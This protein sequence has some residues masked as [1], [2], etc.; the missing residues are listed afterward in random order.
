MSRTKSQQDL[1]TALAAVIAS[2]RRHPDD[3]DLRQARFLLTRQLDPTLSQRAAARLLGVSHTGLSRWIKAGDLATV[4][5]PA[6]RARLPTQAVLD[7]HDRLVDG[8]SHRLEAAIKPSHDRAMK[9]DADTLL[10]GRGRAGDAHRRAQDRAL[11]YHRAV[12]GQLTDALILRARQLLD[13][14]R[15]SGHI[16]DRWADAW[17]RLLGQPLEVIAEQISRDDEH[18][19]DLRQNSPF[20]GALSEAERRT[21]LRATR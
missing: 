13:G 1:L 4:I 15:D 11:A 2:Q 6:G 14:W 12:A 21:L 3:D 9:L 19:D 17:E 5:D 8:R 10:D 20:A 16:D 7:L 18:A